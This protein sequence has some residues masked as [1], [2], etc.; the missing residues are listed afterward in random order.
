MY[1][2]V[3]VE[4]F[5]LLNVGSFLFIRFLRPPRSAQHIL[6]VDADTECEQ[7]HPLGG[8]TQERVARGVRWFFPRSLSESGP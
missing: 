1:E 8:D 5:K 3:P 6:G 7:E 2:S 4:D